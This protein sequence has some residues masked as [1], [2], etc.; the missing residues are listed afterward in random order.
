MYIHLHNQVPLSF[1]N[2]GAVCKKKKRPEIIVCVQPYRLVPSICTRLL[3]LHR[4]IYE[5]GFLTGKE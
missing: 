4:H 5:S 2:Y 1:K 3:H